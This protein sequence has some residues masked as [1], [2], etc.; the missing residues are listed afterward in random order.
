[1]DDLHPLLRVCKSWRDATIGDN[2]CVHFP[3]SVCT[4][5]CS[6]A[7]LPRLNEMLP[8]VCSHYGEV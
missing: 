2:T 8:F 1:M 5:A 3:L 4:R 6:R 7:R